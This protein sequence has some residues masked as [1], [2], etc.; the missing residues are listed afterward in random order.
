MGEA[1]AGTVFLLAQNRLVREALTKVLDR[2]S[3]VS[4]VGSQALSPQTTDDV[5]AAAPDVI[6]LDSYTAST[7]HLQLLRQVQGCLSATRLLM[8]GMDAD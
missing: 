5:V 4:V 8:I 3:D 1:P 7:P 2:K 6:V